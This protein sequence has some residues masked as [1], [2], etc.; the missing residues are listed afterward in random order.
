MFGHCYN[1][2][3]RVIVSCVGATFEHVTTFE[4]IRDMQLIGIDC[5]LCSEQV[6]RSYKF[7]R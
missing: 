2:C 3:V 7:F 5:I 6:G 4:Q 1:N